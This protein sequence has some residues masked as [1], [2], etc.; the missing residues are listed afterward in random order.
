MK[1]VTLR[2]FIHWIFSIFQLIC[3]ILQKLLIFY[4]LITRIITKKLKKT[5]LQNINNVLT[6]RLVQG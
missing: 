6:L 4:I 5:N 3:D 1:F 2:V